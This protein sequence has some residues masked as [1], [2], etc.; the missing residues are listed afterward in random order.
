MSRG[1]EAEQE[2][3]MARRI[4][5]SGYN[6]FRYAMH[7]VGP[8]EQPLPEW[9]NLPE[10]AQDGWFRAV[11]VVKAETEDVVDLPWLTLAQKAYEVYAKAIG[12]HAGPWVN[13]DRKQKVA[14]ESAARHILL[15]F[16]SEDLTDE[17]L[18]DMEAKWTSWADK[19]GAVNVDRP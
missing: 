7:N 6:A 5:I 15:V 12:E 13:L 2:L 8:R 16:E 1:M 17:T 19:R 14:W 3:A 11:F 18:G 10:E 9:D 4:A